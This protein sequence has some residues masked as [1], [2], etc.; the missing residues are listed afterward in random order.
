VRR[1]EHFV[2]VRKDRFPDQTTFRI[3]QGDNAS[4]ATTPNTANTAIA[5]PIVALAMTTP[6]VIVTAI[7][8]T[9][10]GPA[11]SFVPHAKPANAPERTTGTSHAKP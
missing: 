2:G 4:I 1:A 6:T 10:I 8:A 9:T 3:S 7:A 5:R 11:V